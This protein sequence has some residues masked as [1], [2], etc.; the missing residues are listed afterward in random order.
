MTSYFNQFLVTMLAPK[1]TPQ[2]YQ[3]KD[4]FLIQSVVVEE[5][6]ATKDIVSDMVY[7]EISVHNSLCFMAIIVCFIINFLDIVFGIVYQGVWTSE[8]YNSFN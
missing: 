6:T 3:C 7:P 8:F 2:D 4:K 5:G 1:E